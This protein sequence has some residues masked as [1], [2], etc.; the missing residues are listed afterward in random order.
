MLDKIVSLRTQWLADGREIITSPKV[1]ENDVLFSQNAG[2]IF[3]HNVMLGLIAWRKKN[4]PSPYFNQAMDDIS[5]YCEILSSKGASLSSMPLSTASLISSLVEREF[6]FSLTCEIGEA[7][8]L[9]LDCLVAAEIKGGAG[10]GSSEEAIGILAESDRQAL[11]AR[12]YKVYFDI[13][14]EPSESPLLENLVVSASKN[15]SDRAKDRFYSGGQDINGGGKYNDIVVDYRLGAILKHVSYS[16]DSV[17][18]W[19]WNCGDMD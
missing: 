9:Y 15:Y 18:S 1:R 4:D 13:L 3:R 11:A 16:G 10:S 12:T 5:T 8:D 7:A 19:R 6:E 17:H 2:D 14:G